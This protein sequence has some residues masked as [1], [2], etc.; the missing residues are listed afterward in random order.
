MDYVRHQTTRDVFYTSLFKR[1]CFRATQPSILFFYPIG[2]VNFLGKTLGLSASLILD[3]ALAGGEGVSPEAIV[4]PVAIV[5]GL[6]QNLYVLFECGLPSA[7]LDDLALEIERLIRFHPIDEF[8]GQVHEGV[9]I[10]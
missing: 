1:D 2:A 4:R 6:G 5:D 10:L 8:K 7:R 3:P 9:V